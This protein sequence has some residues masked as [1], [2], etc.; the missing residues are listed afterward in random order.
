M[1]F[2]ILLCNLVFT[3]TVNLK[4]YNLL[5]S[6][7]LHQCAWCGSLPDACQAAAPAPLFKH[8][9]V[10]GGGIAYLFLIPVSVDRF[11][12]EAGMG[13]VILKTCSRKGSCTYEASAVQQWLCGSYCMLQGSKTFPIWCSSPHDEPG[14]LATHCTQLSEEKQSLKRMPSVKIVWTN[15]MLWIRATAVGYT[16]LRCQQE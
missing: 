7:G 10:T 11:I 12:W 6:L 16:F 2:P 13:I 4:P 15:V 3:D 5:K 14:G 8:R 1:C 9:A